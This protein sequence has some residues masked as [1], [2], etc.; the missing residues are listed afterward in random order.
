MGNL[1]AQLSQYSKSKEY[2]LLSLEV[3]KKAGY[4]IGQAVSLRNLAENATNQDSSYQ[5][6]A[7]LHESLK[8]DSISGYKIG[9]AR[10]HRNLGYIYLEKKDYPRS[11]Y[12]FNKA[13]DNIIDDK[14]HIDLGSIYQ[15]LTKVAL[16]QNR[17]EDAKSYL[18]L[19]YEFGKNIDALEYNSDQ[20]ELMS[21]YFSRIGNHR[22]AYE[23]L[24]LFNK[25]QNS[26]LNENIANQIT[27]LNIQYETEKKEAEIERLES[28]D[29]YKA[30]QL[31]RQQLAIVGLL[32]V[33]TILGMLWYRIRTQKSQ[34]EEQKDVISKALN[35]KDI[36]LREIHHRVKNNLQFVSSL[37]NLQSRHVEDETALTALKEGQNRV[38]SMAL[39]H[40]NLYQEDNLTGI[41]IKEY[42]EKLTNSLFSSY[43]ISPDRITLDM[44]IENVN[45]DVDTVIPLG[46]IINELISNALKHAFPKETSGKIIVQLK[47]E[48]SELVL[49]VKD[50][51]VGLKGEDETLLKK[52]FGYRL[53]NAFKSQLDAD[54][55]ID[56]H[57][58]TAVEMR[59]KDYQKV[60]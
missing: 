31:K 16:D 38:K 7:Y 46:L 4:T 36:L 42:L 34:I 52:S 30:N 26:L 43:N 25:S 15:G 6:L 45:L 8:L 40:Q 60:A 51:G 11:I 21:A 41:E 1:Y 10:A 56:G 28:E 12:H 32:L 17:L 20:H 53:I 44:D 22:Q 47:E 33:L 13:L 39:I 54:L 9:T 55:N 18:D 19:S 23:Q 2:I 48:N 57:Q 27:G 35:E 5:A 24:L 37:L 14:N 50:N 29:A 58:G 59:I 49:N 3:A